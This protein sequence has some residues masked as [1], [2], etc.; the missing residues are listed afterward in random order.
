MEGRFINVRKLVSLDIT[1]HGPRFI[2]AEYGIGTPG[3]LALGLLVAKTGPLILGL[4]LMATGAN[5]VPLLAY[6]ILA[7]RSGTARQD[8]DDDLS[9]DKHYVRRYSVQQLLILVPFAIVAL[10]AIQKLKGD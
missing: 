3:V 9:R 5:Y 1:L 2:M 6:A 10:A 4:Y 7:V 8:V